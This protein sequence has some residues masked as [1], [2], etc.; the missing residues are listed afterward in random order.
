MATS[1]QNLHRW[2]ETILLFDINQAGSIPS[3][4]QL[5]KNQ[6]LDKSIAVNI[7]TVPVM[8]IQLHRR[9]CCEFLI[10]PQPESYW[11]EK[12]P[13]SSEIH[14]TSHVRS[15]STKMQTSH[16]QIKMPPCEAKN[17]TSYSSWNQNK[18]I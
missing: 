10:E 12:A 11:Q 9:Y 8:K 13:R 15:E 14:Q 5:G 4:L 17:E 2:H 16:P 1:H 7:Q 6:P 18:R 3:V